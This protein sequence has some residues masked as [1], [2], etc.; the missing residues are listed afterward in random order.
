[1]PSLSLAVARR[2]P[3]RDE[4]LSLLSEQPRGLAKGTGNGVVVRSGIWLRT[5][6]LRHSNAIGKT[7]L[8]S[9]AIR[10]PAFKSASVAAEISIPPLSER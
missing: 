1:M 2:D 5:P 8:T 10:A 9:S 7:S 3:D 4:R 6:P